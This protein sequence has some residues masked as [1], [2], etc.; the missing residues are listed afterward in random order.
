[1]RV[2]AIKMCRKV[3]KPEGSKQAR[4]REHGERETLAKLYANNHSRYS[5]HVERGNLEFGLLK[6]V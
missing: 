4:A 1:M 6:V 3:K 5:T 2:V